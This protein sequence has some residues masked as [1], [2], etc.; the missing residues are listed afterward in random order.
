MINEAQLVHGA[1]LYLGAAGTTRITTG[2]TAV[3]EVTNVGDN[4]RQR[5]VSSVQPL[6]R[7]TPLKAA[8]AIDPGSISF[9]LVTDDNDAGQVA[10][11]AAS[12]TKNQ[13]GFRLEKGGAT[14]RS[15]VG[16]IESYSDN[17]GGQNSFFMV[18]VNFNLTD[19]YE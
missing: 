6:G 5:T 4:T 9:Q 1:T 17:A 15:A 11:K 18:T 13:Y 10:L 2:G 14:I 8:G 16:F 3:G 19:F 12:R 7:D